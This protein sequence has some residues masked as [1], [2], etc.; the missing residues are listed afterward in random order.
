MPCFRVSSASGAPA[1][2]SFNTPTICDSLNL[3]FFICSPVHCG[4]VQDYA[5]RQL[6]EPR[7]I[8]MR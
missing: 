6:G 5:V 8:P 7:L 1:S 3:D 2:P 4:S